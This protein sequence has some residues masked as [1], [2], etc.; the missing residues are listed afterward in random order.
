MTTRENNDNAREIMLPNHS[1]NENRDSNGIAV[2]VLD[3]S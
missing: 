3:F 2:F 1:K